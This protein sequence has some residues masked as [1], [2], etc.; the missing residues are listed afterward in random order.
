MHGV[1]LAEQ[2]A[3][4]QKAFKP[5]MNVQED[6]P[7]FRVDGH[8]QGVLRS[9]IRPTRQMKIE[10]QCFHVRDW[11]EVVHDDDSDCAPLH[12]HHLDHRYLGRPRPPIAPFRI[13]VWGRVLLPS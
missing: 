8:L 9:H 10:M 5:N 7:L 13:R 3:K 4:R 1:T 6:V 12:H 2:F 11:Q